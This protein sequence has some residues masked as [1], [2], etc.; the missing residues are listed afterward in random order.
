MAWIAKE[1]FNVARTYK[2]YRAGEIV[3]DEALNA[4]EAKTAKD[5][6]LIEDQK[7]TAKAKA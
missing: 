7:K 2:Q 1:T 4:T 5:K 3:P 6:G